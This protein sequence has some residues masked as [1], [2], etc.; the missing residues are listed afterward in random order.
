[1]REK[2]CR[3]PAMKISPKGHTKT[4]DITHAHIIIQYYIP[5]NKSADVSTCHPYARKRDS[6]SLRR[7][8]TILAG[9]DRKVRQANTRH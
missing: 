7:K 1:M 6:L 3:Y 4:I 2:Q 9:A 8:I 5:G